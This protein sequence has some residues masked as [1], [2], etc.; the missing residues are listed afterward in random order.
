MDSCWGFTTGRLCDRFNAQGIIAGCAAAALQQ[1]PR[2][3]ASLIPEHFF[4]EHVP[5][6]LPGSSLNSLVV[7]AGQ[8]S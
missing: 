8:T 5:R 6:L 1:I 7:N 2:A 3:N 4:T